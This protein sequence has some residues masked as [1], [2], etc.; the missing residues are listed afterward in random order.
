MTGRRPAIPERSDHP[1][2]GRVTGGQA[3]THA[4]SVGERT[5]I[6][7]ECATSTYFA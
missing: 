6:N 3:F 1:T 5:L 2:G 4:G 7:Q